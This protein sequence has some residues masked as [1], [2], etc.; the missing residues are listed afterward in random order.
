M[1]SIDNP[2]TATM[3]LARRQAIAAVAERHGVTIIEDDAYGAL[4]DDAPPPIAAIAPETTWHIASLSKCATPALRIAYVVSPGLPQTLRLSAEIRSTS[5]MAS[6]L[7]SALA[8]RWAANG[9]LDDIVDAIRR[10]NVERQKIARRVLGEAAAAHPEGHHLW[11]TLPGHWRRA[12]FVG[13]ALHSGLAVVPS[14]AFATT[15]RP[16]DAVRVSLGIVPDRQQLD[17]A[18]QRL[19]FLIER[20]PASTS[21]I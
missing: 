14:D 8:A 19:A 1:P 10:E 6:P 21:I 17:R 15:G 16:P 5:L 3:G 18:L 7:T 9:T 12:E 11:L 13:H 2:T 4:A 20:K